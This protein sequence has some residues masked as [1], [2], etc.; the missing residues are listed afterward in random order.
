MSHAQS[1]VEYAGFWRRLLAVLIDTTLYSI[2]ITPIFVALYGRDYFY[3]QK[4]STELFAVYSAADFIFT[5]IIPIG[6]TIIFWRYF[7][8]TPGKLLLDCK[9]VNANTHKPLHWKQASLRYL[10]YIASAVPL[11]LGFA[12]IG[13]DKRKQ[14]L[15]DK[16]AKTVVLHTPHNYANMSLQELMEPFE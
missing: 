7:S 16:L 14:G 15:H 1:S 13:L 2:L 8:A 9:I 3:W 6:L 11:Y 4:T 12:I 5:I 10:A